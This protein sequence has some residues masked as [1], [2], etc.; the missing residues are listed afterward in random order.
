MT[1]PRRALVLSLLIAF[2][3]AAAGDDTGRRLA[4]RALGPTPFVEDLRELCD[5]I[6]GRP[7]GSPAC[8]RAVTWAASRLRA[9]GLDSVT[10]EPFTVPALWSAAPATASC[11]EPEKFPIRVAAAP[12][13]SPTPE[14]VAIEAPLVDAG[15]GSPQEFEKLGAAGRGAIALVK[16]E[17][18]KNLG[19]LFAEYMRDA[20]MLRAAHEAGAAAILLMSTHEGGLLYRHPVMVNGSI[21]PLPVALASREQATRLARLLE[22]GSVRVSLSTP[23]RAGGPYEARNVVGEIR[24]R[25][26]PEE[27]VLL[28]AHLDSWDLGTGALDNGVNASLVI[29]VARGFEELGV[30][31][32]RTVRF[33]LFTGE[34]E[35]MW[36]SAGYVKRHAAELNDHV[37]AVILDI[38]SGRIGGFYLNGRDELR[39]P[40]DEA[41]AAVSGLGP[42]AHPAEAVDGTDNFDFLLSG[43]PNL[44][45]SQ[46]V[47]PYLPRYHA[48]S[49]VF[50]AVDQREAKA[51]AAIASA[52]VW[53]LAETPR[54]PAPRQS[55]AEVQALIGRTGLEADMKAF[56]QWDDWL[57]GRRGVDAK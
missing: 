36:G 54:R 43:V 20:P 55:R 13:A 29:D 50:E 30:K 51:N 18:M 11:L 41:L 44:I 40:V 6:G 42:F 12:F 2:H 21:A 23:G 4:G 47:A 22:K 46:D 9:A 25:E 7:T 33:V 32:R 26:R 27:V 48:E 53:W 8:D 1:A 15:K 3:G 5:R 16:T 34:E 52:L 56:G 35:G 14:G 39:G 49:D 10:L 57:A 19:D 28:G 24:G 37:A 45:A 31:P 38:G 17:E